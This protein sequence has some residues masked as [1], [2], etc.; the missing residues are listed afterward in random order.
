MKL[1]NHSHDD[2]LI[3]WLPNHQVQVSHLSIPRRCRA[4]FLRIQRGLLG[5]CITLTHSIA[6]PAEATHQGTHEP[7]RRRGSWHGGFFLLKDDLNMFKRF[8]IILVKTYS[9]WVASWSTLE[10]FGLKMKH[11][12]SQKYSL[13]RS[14]TRFKIQD[15]RMRSNPFVGASELYNWV[16]INLYLQGSVPTPSHFPQVK[17]QPNA[18]AGKPLHTADCLPRK[19]SWDH[20]TPS[21]IWK[22]RQGFPEKWSLS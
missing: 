22:S 12:L 17:G 4:R 14:S 3:F 6:Q 11:Y 13:E 21:L 15:I 5:R 1:W 2:I 19:R 8:Y 7:R 9:V 16:T 10:A 18:R 20:H